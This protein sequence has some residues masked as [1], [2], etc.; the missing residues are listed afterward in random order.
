MGDTV[1][2][3]SYLLGEYTPQPFM[4]NTG[5]LSREIDI[6]LMNVWVKCFYVYHHRLH[7][8]DCY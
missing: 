6:I 7:T 1:V 8:S 5:S 3:Q 2:A 4:V